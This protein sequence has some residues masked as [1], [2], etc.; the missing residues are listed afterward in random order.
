MIVSGTGGAKWIPYHTFYDNK[1][2]TIGGLFSQSFFIF[3]IV[4]FDDYLI[5]STGLKF[6]FFWN[7]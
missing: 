7:D 4:R 1:Q 6:V 5:E 2:I 3:Q